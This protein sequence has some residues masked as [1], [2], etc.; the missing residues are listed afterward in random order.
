LGILLF[1]IA[2]SA[3]WNHNPVRFVKILAVFLVLVLSAGMGYSL[4]EHV[5]DGLLYL[6]MPRIRSGQFLPGTVAL[7]D[8]LRYGF[9][10]ELFQI[11]RV[12]SSTLGLL[13][14]LGVLL[15]AFLVW[16]RK[17]TDRFVLVLINSYLVAGLA[18]SPLLHL[19]GNQVDCK[20]DIILAN[21]GIGAHLAGIIP[22]DSLVYWDGGN[23]FTP[24][25]YVPHARIFPPQINGGYTYRIG[26]DPDTLYRFS[27]WNNELASEWRDSADIFIIESKRFSTWRDFLTPQEFQELEAPA[28]TPSC[29]AGSALRIFHRLP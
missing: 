4:F 8:L 21:E 20:R 17:K 9:S 16:K 15:L 6:P 29:D 3:A 5:G 27:H 28:D 26:G 7:V 25:V 19:G 1:A 11:K 2:L 18:L 22:P 24:M 14:G 10:L 23:S 12:I 13:L